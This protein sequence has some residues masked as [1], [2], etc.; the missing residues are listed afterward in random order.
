MLLAKPKRRVL[1][2]ADGMQRLLPRWVAVFFVG[3]SVVLVPWIFVLMFST[4]Q[5]FGLARHWKLVWVGFDCFLL[6]GFAATAWRVLTR[7]PRGATTAAATSTMLLIDAW[8][9]ILTARHPTNEIIAVLM[10]VC[11]EIPCSL[12]CF[13]VARKIVGMFEQAAPYLRREGFRVV[14]G[15]L[16]PP[17]GRDEQEGDGA[18]LERLQGRV[19]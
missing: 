14:D 3:A 10:A 6:L 1:S 2:K 4:P 19:G 9:D 7:S 18:D 12:I 13:Y 5:E 17:P 8:F 15:R 16:V 11:A